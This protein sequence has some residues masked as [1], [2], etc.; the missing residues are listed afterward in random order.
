MNKVVVHCYKE[1]EDR[2]QTE[3][4]IKIDQGLISKGILRAMLSTK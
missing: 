4:G 3:L 1:L 2:H